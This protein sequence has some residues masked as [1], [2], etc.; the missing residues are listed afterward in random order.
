MK[1]VGRH[2]TWKLIFAFAAVYLIWGSTYLAI[3]FAIESIPPLVMLGIRFGIAGVFLFGIMCAAGV[4]RP[5]FALWKN[6]ALIGTLTLAVG[7]GAVAWAEM[8]VASGVAALLVTTVPLFMVMLEWLWKKGRRPNA[9]IV[10]GLTLGVIGIVLLVNP[11][12]ILAGAS[13]QAS[14][15]MIVI[16]IGSFSWSY[17]SILSRDLSLPDNP[18]MSTAIQM[19]SG[20]L[21]LVIAGLIRGEA[22]QFDIMAIFDLI[23]AGMGI[24]DFLWIYR[25]FQLLRLADEERAGGSGIDLCVCESRRSSPAGMAAGR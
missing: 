16:L 20:G 9:A 5:G 14:I 3:R 7:T 8:Y 11:E 1:H 22:A 23:V 12:E 2:T 24:P 6:G 21:V 25:C 10:G 17:G 15:A 13:L 19:I 4:D 18:F